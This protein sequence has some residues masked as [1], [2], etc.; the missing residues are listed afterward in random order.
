MKKSGGTKSKVGGQN[1]K[2]SPPYISTGNLILEKT[3]KAVFLELYNDG[4]L[5]KKIAH[6]AKKLHIDRKTVKEHLLTLVPYGVVRNDGKAGSYSQWYVTERGI[7]VINSG[8][9][10]LVMSEREEGDK[11]PNNKDK[12]ESVPHNIKVKV[13][14]LEKPSRK[15]WLESWHLASLKNNVNFYTH[16]MHGVGMTYTGLNVIF[17][18]PPFKA[19][20]SDAHD[21]AYKIAIKLCHQLEDE[22]EGLK[23]GHITKKDITIQII[24]QHMALV[25]DPFAKWLAKNNISYS[26]GVIDIDSSRGKTKSEI[27]AVDSKDAHIHMHKYINLIEDVMLNDLPSL[28]DITKLINQNSKTINALAS[29]QAFL[30]ES[31]TATQTQ[32]ENLTKLNH[33]AVERLSKLEQTQHDGYWRNYQ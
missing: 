3:K 27:E 10:V 19:L 2:P 7:K 28:S 20:P 21:I 16:R 14:V 17:S 5:H 6:I 4:K 12:L 9:Y 22:I 8:G 1:L 23:L 18:I 29:N 33:L 13:K 26:D 31:I 30:L 32:I 15:D 11:K 25:N 24:N